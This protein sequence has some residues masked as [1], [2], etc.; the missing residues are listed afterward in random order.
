MK[1][2]KGGTGI[3]R[4]HKVFTLSQRSTPGPCFKIVFHQ[5]DSNI[6]R[7]EIIYFVDSD[8]H[9]YN[10]KRAAMEHSFCTIPCHINLGGCSGS[11]GGAGTADCYNISVK[12]YYKQPIF[13]RLLGKQ[14]G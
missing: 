13:C 1:Q 4:F 5:I 7:K 10:T 2:L 9:P 6:F 14:G 12:L 11:T 8:H 3:P